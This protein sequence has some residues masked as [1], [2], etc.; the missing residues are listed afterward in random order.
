MVVTAL[1]EQGL[2]IVGVEAHISV[3]VLQ[4]EVDRFG[5]L[6]LG[7]EPLSIPPLDLFTY[8]FF[9]LCYLSPIF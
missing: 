9:L 1:S 8:E 2:L 4:H 7:G 6:T 3:S 5:V